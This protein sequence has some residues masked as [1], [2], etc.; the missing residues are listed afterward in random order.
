MIADFN[1]LRNFEGEFLDNID[2]DGTTLP[3]SAAQAGSL[4]ADFVQPLRHLPEGGY[5]V[6]VN[7]GTLTTFL[8]SETDS[9]ARAQ[10]A[11][12][13]NNRASA[14]NVPLLQAAL[15]KRDEAAHLLGYPNWATYAIADRMAAKPD[16]VRHFLEDLNERLLPRAKAEVARLV[17]LKGRLN[18][19]PATTLD[20]GDYQYYSA[21]LRRLEY[22]LD[23]RVVREYFPLDHVVDGIMNIYGRL[24]GVA[25]ERVTP[26]NAWSNDVKKFIMTDA[27]TG[28]MVGY[29][30]LD[31]FARPGK[32]GHI[33]NIEL[34]P[35]RRLPNGDVR[36]PATA[37]V[38]NFP[39]PSYGRQALLSHSDVSTLFHEMGHAMAALLADTPYDTLSGPFVRDFVEAPAQMLENWPWDPAIIKEI[40]YNVRTGEPMSDPMIARLIASRNFGEAY[41]WS[42]NVAL[43]LI[44]LDFHTAGAHVD[45]TAIYEDV[46]AHDAP[47]PMQPGTHPQA[48]WTHEMDGYDACYYAYAWGKVLAQ[49]MFAVFNAAGLENPT[50]GQRYRE[51]LL[52]PDR[53]YD[54]Q[55]EVVRFVGRQPTPNAFYRDLGLDREL[56]ASMH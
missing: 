24:F 40:S 8:T 32:Y 15:A 42:R 20:P 50:A 3:I 11:L 12:A 10:F 5:A 26:A 53:A 6:P 28:R 7:E 33:A 55:T 52:A 34:L 19:Y 18:G 48:S 23:P 38:A 16:R 37:V 44:D 39:A 2:N 54:P 51:L 43:S 27:H 56:H 9:E 46:L 21:Q 47:L 14:A 45:T 36:A 22:N 31:F 49:D 35:E 17:A 41:H 30:Y 29:L 25:F 1:E 13:Y 4:P